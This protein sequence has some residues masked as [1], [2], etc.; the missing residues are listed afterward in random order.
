MPS[1]PLRASIDVPNSVL[2]I[3]V[4]LT[5]LLTSALLIFLLVVAVAASCHAK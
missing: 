5:V 2:L 1:A 3:G 4:L